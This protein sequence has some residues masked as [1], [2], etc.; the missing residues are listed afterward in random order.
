MLLSLLLGAMVE[1]YA[2]FLFLDIPCRPIAWFPILVSCL[3]VIGSALLGWNLP[4]T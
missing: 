1:P 2:S 4:G 3:A